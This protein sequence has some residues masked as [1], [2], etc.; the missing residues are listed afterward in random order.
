MQKS[1]KGPQAKIH[2]WS[3]KPE[4]KGKRV[5]Q[6]ESK[7]GRQDYSRHDGGTEVNDVVTDIALDQLYALKEYYLANVKVSV[8]KCE[9]LKLKTTGQG[10][11]DNSL[12]VWSAERRK[13]ITASNVGK[14]A[15]RKSTTKVRKLYSKAVTSYQI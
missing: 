12:Q 14:I 1:W 7:W 6:A 13:Q 9:E 8:E 10:K 15:K 2:R 4:E 5:S 3:K 11:C